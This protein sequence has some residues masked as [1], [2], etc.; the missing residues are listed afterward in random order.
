MNSMK[1][2]AISHTMIAAVLAILAV[3]FL[4]SSTPWWGY[5]DIFSSMCFGLSAVLSWR[6]VWK[7]HPRVI[8]R[9]ITVTETITIT[10]KPVGTDAV[11]VGVGADAE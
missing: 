6:K 3:V 1:K 5:L 4:Y 2:T 11:N 8:S 10:K 7:A 9:K